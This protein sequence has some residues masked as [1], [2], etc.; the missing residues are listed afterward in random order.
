[1]NL[2]K[3]PLNH[4]AS[5]VIFAKMEDVFDILMKKL[6]IGIPEF[7]L[8][9]WAKVQLEES[10]SGKEVLTVHGMD[11]NGGPFDLF[12]KA[13]IEGKLGFRSALN[14]EQM[15]SKTKYTISLTPQGHYGE[16]D[17][18]LTI[19]RS[20]LLAN[21]KT[22]KINMHFNP[23]FNVGWELVTANDNGKN[24]VDTV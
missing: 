17:L 1:M 12:K 24:F 10:K 3:T 2:Q 9:R 18:H 4:L 19:P 15:Q 5:L 6:K 23:K 21:D 11:A 16:K 8:N 7:T 22:L 13:K 20:L 14:E